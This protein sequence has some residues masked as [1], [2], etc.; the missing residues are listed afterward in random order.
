MPLSR[1]TEVDLTRVQPR[2]TCVRQLA[3]WA[4]NVITIDALTEDAGSEQP[5]EPPRR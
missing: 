1:F 3:D 5:G 4:S 2:P